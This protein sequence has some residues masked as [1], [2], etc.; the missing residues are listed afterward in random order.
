[1][2]DGRP[3][4]QD[5]LYAAI[6]TRKTSRKINYDAMSSIFDDDGNFSTDLLEDNEPDKNEQNE[7]SIGV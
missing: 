2:E 7:I 5:A 6:S 1:M 3:T 4:P